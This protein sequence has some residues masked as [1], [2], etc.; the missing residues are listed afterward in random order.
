[1]LVPAIASVSPAWAQSSSAGIL[2][3]GN[4]VVTGFS[5][6]PLPD[7][8]APG[9]DPGDQAF[10]DPNGPSARVF[11]LQ[12]PGAPPQAQV[13]PAANPF[14][15]T[16]AQVGQVFGVALDSAAPPNIY[17]AATSAYGLPIVVPGQGGAP[18]RLHQG[19][20]GASFMAGLFGPAAQG[21]GSV[22]NIVARLF[23]SAAQGGGTG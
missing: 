22:T 16:A 4:A 14:T 13:I 3:P 20:P 12:A 19:A 9:D 17:V 1:M 23:G 5:G 7:L 2:A 18:K 10:I 21:G 11:N 15:V 6:A 8:V